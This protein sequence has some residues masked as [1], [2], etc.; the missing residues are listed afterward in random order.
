MA[1]DSIQ[2][3]YEKYVPQEQ[4][5]YAKYYHYILI[6]L[7]SALG[8]MIVIVSVLLYQS[9]HQPL[10]SFHAMQQDKKEIGLT[11]FEAP[12]LRPETILRWASK[13]A[14]TAY[15]FDLLRYREQVEAAKPYFTDLG[16]QDYLRSVTPLLQS[17]VKNQLFVYGIVAGTP[18]ISNQG[19]LPGKGNAW[20]VQIPFLVTYRSANTVENQKFYVSLL[21]VE[22][23]T[24]INPQGIGI[25]QFVMSVRRT[26]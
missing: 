14:V 11:P 3:K 10:P 12:N 6:F 16:W 4:G 13:A 22:V 9:T 23:P 2:Q 24:N 1:L 5:F 26:M 19:P 17:I 25:D 21:L 8:L 20:R 18:V 15:T 7:L